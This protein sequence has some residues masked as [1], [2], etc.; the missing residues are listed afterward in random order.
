MKNDADTYITCSAALVDGIVS[1]SWVK[2]FMFGLTPC[3]F[4][5]SSNPEHPPTRINL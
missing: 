3:L 4:I 1:R 2:V 5:C